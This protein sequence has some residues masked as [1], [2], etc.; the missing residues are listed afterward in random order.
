MSDE[1]VIIENAIKYYGSLYILNNITV[2]FSKNKIYGIVGHNGSG[3][4]IFLKCICGL[5]PLNS[6]RV[7][8][9]NKIIGKDVDIA[10]DI[11]IIIETPGFLPNYSGFRN[12][13]FLASIRNKI[14]KKC[15]VDIMKLVGLDPQNKKHVAKYSLGMRQRLGIAQAIMENNQIL[16]LDEPMNGLDKQGIIDINKLLI[17][18]RNDGKTIILATHRNEDINDLCDVVYEIENGIMSK[19]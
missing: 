19:R 8:V 6:G 12:L 10:D 16:L 17:D 2:A 7:I 3:K 18:L 11:G 13:E 5:I 9:N 1:V 15:I 14:D 4:T